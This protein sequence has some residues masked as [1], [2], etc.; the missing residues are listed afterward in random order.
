MCCLPS[1]PWV[2]TQPRL[3]GCDLSILPEWGHFVERFK[4]IA[5]NTSPTRLEVQE[6]QNSTARDRLIEGYLPLVRAVAGR[7]GRRGDQHDDIIQVG[8]IGLIKAVD[9]FDPERGVELRVYAMTM[10]VGEIQRH[11]RD[12]G[13][14]VHVPR[15]LKELNGKLLKFDDELTGS[16]GRSPTI[17]ELASAAGVH[18]EQAIEALEA[19]RAYATIS[20]SSP[21]GSDPYTV[22]GDTV[23][24][25]LAPFGVADDHDLISRG[26][27][28][29]GERERRIILLRFFEELTQAQIAVRMGISQ[30]QVSRLISRSLEKIRLLPERPAELAA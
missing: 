10:I 21:F 8:T 19:G 6:W 23:A 28:S 11:F 9:R 22:L 15:S 24:D 3:L 17:G 1:A 4:A 2:E 20:L 16:L 7:Y 27:D 29:L 26:F 14:A 13:W 30:M 5:P 25:T 18:Q 12:R